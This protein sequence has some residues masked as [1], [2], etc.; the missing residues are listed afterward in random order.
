M[1]IHKQV[2]F[3]SDVLF[4]LK[5]DCTNSPSFLLGFQIKQKTERVAPGLLCLQKPQLPA[6]VLGGAAMLQLRIFQLLCWP[7]PEYCRK[8]LTEDFLQKKAQI[9]SAA[10]IMDLAETD[11]LLPCLF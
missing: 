2:C 6:P 11:V 7:L 4:D 10:K 9:Q 8:L 1:T 3:K 5:L